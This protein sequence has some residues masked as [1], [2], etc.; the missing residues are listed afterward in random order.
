MAPLDAGHVLLGDTLCSAVGADTEVRGGHQ[1]PD[2]R[3]QAVLRM[4]ATQGT[5]FYEQAT[6]KATIK[7]PQLPNQTV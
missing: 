1:Y 7:C 5:I 4:E 3:V 2:G 6:A